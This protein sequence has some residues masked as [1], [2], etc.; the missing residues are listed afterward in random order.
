[1]GEHIVTYTYIDGE[2]G[3][4]GFGEATITVL[5]LPE[6]TFT[7]PQ[8]EICEDALPFTLTDGM[9][10]GGTYSGTGIVDGEFDP[11][12]A[13]VGEHIITYTYIDTDTGCEGFAEATITVLE[14]P[15]VSCPDDQLVY[16]DDEPLDLTAL[17]AEPPGGTFSGPGVND[18]GNQFDPQDAEPGE[19]TIIYTYVDENGCENFCTFIISL[20]LQDDPEYTLT[21]AVDGLG[22]ITGDYTVGTHTVTAGTS[23]SLTAVPE[24]GHSFVEWTDAFSFTMPAGNVTFTAHFEVD[25]P[26]PEF[27]LTLEVEGLGSITGDYTVG[28]YTVTYGTE[29][30]LTAV[31]D[32]GHHFVQWTDTTGVITSTVENFSFNMPA[33][34]VTLTAHFQEDMIVLTFGKRQRSMFLI[35]LLRRKAII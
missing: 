35:L 21:L 15:E 22:S 24:T 18:D 28:T 20:E 3:C 10:E 31:P 26:D 13:G 1:M 11:Q 6:V 9:P 17:G 29:V 14:L 8:S 5:E 12:V 23:V 33:A 2:T 27:T 16:L 25:V 19:H 7:L 32:T 30:I 4:E 34:N